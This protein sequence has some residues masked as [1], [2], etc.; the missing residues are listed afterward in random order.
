MQSLEVSSS[1]FGKPV[2]KYIGENGRVLDAE[3]PAACRVDKRSFDVVGL[4]ECGDYK[5]IG[6]SYPYWELRS[7]T[8]KPYNSGGISGVWNNREIEFKQNWYTLDLKWSY[9]SR[10]EYYLLEKVN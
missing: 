1:E 7:A 8:I 2:F 6:G 3:S 10:I 4:I 9:D 5:F